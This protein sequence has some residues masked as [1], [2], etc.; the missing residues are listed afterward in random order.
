MMTK[1]AVCC[2]LTLAAINTVL[3]FAFPPKP[4]PVQ[5]IWGPQ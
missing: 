4:E 3:D 2:F 5:S 1:A